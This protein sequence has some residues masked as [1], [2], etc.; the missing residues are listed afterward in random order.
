MFARRNI[1]SAKMFLKMFLSFGTTS[2]RWNLSVMGE[3]FFSKVLFYIIIYFLGE[4]EDEIGHENLH[5]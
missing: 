3:Y 1:S 2:R 4:F 5:A